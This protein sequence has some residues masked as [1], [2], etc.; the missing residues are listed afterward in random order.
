MTSRWLMNLVAAAVLAGAVWIL[1]PTSRP[2]PET[3]FNLLD[4]RTLRSSDLRG[5]SLLITFWSVNCETCM[6]DMPRF[7][8]LYESLKDHNFM[9]IGVAMPHDPPPAVIATVERHNPGYPIALDVHGEVNKAFGGI[10]VT[11]TTYLI[12]PDGNINFS[13]RGPLDE[14][15]VRATL[16]TF[17]G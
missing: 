6:R 16:L 2:M 8:R 9:V 3:T 14:T 17:Q 13:E 15:R 1:W 12:G 4:G 10:S 11:P 5:Q 7:N